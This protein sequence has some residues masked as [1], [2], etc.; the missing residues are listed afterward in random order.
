MTDAPFRILGIAG[1]L[2]RASFNAGLIRA[3]REVA[4][5]G[6]TVESADL[7]PLPFYNADVEAEG[8]PAPVQA[9]KEQIRAADALLIAA[10]EYNYGY[11]AVLKNALDWASR[12][13]DNVLRHK[14]VALVGASGGMFGTARA[15]LGLRQVFI[16]TE[17]FVMPRPELLVPSARDKFDAEGNLTDPQIRE[18]LGTIVEALIAWTKRLYHERYTA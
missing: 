16:N 5:P 12:P 6:V 9:F 13:Y 8:V 17:T 7:A 3:A 10:P 4:P 14:P 15:Q 18:R 11:T 1:S 2:R